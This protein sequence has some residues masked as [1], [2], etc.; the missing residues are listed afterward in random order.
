MFQKKFSTLKWLYFL[1]LRIFSNVSIIIFIEPN[2]IST[3]KLFLLLRLRVLFHVSVANLS[4][5]VILIYTVTYICKCLHHNFLCKHVHFNVKAI[6]IV[7]LSRYFPCLRWNSL[8]KC[9]LYCDA[10]VTFDMC[11]SQFCLNMSK[12][13]RI[14]LDHFGGHVC[15]LR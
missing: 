6:F 15:F 8:R 10:Y 2:F 5:N 12:F 1:R 3:Q 7:T 13:M 14:D 11:S 4:P 9:H